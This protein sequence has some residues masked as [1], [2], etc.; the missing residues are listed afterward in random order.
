MAPAALGCPP[1]RAEQQAGLIDWLALAALPPLLLLAL[2][3]RLE[4]LAK[5]P[6]ARLEA[7]QLEAAAPVAE[8]ARRQP[9]RP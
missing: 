8:A 3:E 2:V 7:H 6:E 4:R 9:V 1:G 5:P